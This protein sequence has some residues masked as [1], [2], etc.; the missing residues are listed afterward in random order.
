MIS[1]ARGARVLGR[2][3]LDGRSQKFL[4]PL[5]S[6]TLIGEGG[7]WMCAVEDRDATLGTG[8]QVSVKGAFEV[9]GCIG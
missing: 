4:T 5:L 2:A 9:G 3:S 1:C 8:R 6:S 7:N